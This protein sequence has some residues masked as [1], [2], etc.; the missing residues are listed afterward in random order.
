MVQRGPL[1]FFPGLA[2]AL[3]AWSASL[4]AAEPAGEARLPAA[5]PR[6]VSFIADVQ[7]LFTA[8]CVDCH[9]PDKQKGGWRADDPK[10]ALHAGDSFGPNIL[11]GNSA[12]SP[13]I[14]FVAHTHPELKMPEKGTPLTAEEV[15]ILRAWIDQGADWPEGAT[16]PAA[17]PV[18]PLDWWSLQAPSRPPVPEK[19]NAS[20]PIDRFLQKALAEKGLRPAPEA[21]RR[22]LLRRLSFDL[23]GL[24]PSPEDVASFLAD[25]DP[26]A[27]EKRVDAYLASPRYG[28]RW[29]R[30]WL[31]VAHYGGPHGYDKDK[32]RPNAWP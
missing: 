4:H 16:V 1:R 23:T 5:A 14:Q 25:P 13:L 11:P 31:D 12:A 10:Y 24:P 27:Y 2:A 32:A 9:G 29:A 17:K 20:H 22:T 21:D 30:H 6:K 3:V 19:A 18:D 15:G 28:E 8:H 26:R 7:P